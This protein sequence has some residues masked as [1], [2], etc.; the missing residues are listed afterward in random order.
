MKNE[1]KRNE[2]KRTSVDIPS[3]SRNLATAIFERK[4]GCSFPGAYC[5]VASQSANATVFPSGSRNTNVRSKCEPP[6][7][8]ADCGSRVRTKRRTSGRSS[9]A[10]EA[11]LKGL[12]RGVSGLKARDPGRRESPGEKVLKERRSPRQRGRVGTSVQQNAPWHPSAPPPR[13]RPPPRRRRRTP[14]RGSR[15]TARSG[16]C[17]CE[18]GERALGR[19]R[20]GCEGRE[21]WRGER[22]ATFAARRVGGGRGRGSRTLFYS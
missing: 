7:R 10:S 22:G 17:R 16:F 11:E 14:R 2:T 1:T 5:P 19:G 3:L 20:E 15:T 9:K 21:G 4:M 6:G 13:G 8:R 12:R 18:G